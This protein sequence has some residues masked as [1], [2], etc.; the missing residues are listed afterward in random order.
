MRK[1]KRCFS[2]LDIPLQSSV[3]LFCLRALLLF[4]TTNNP[5][6]KNFI[7]ALHH[8]LQARTQRVLFLPKNTAAPFWF[9][10]ELR[11]LLRGRFRG[12]PVEKPTFFLGAS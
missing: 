8:P 2:R 11:P 3:P 12:E 5:T 6:Q 9:L 7:A 1:T 10:R 4:Y